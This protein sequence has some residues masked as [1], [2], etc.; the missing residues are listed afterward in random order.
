VSDPRG[1]SACGDACGGQDDVRCR[2]D[3][4]WCALRG[5]TALAGMATASGTVGN[6]ASDFV[7]EVVG[8]PMLPGKPGEVVHVDTP[9]LLPSAEAGPKLGVP[10]WPGEPVGPIAVPGQGQ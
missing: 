10:G 4:G 2:A 3:E 7:G 8:T 5:S 1:L 9:G 6:W